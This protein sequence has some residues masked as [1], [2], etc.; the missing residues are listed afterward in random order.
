MNA[1]LE[2]PTFDWVERWLDVWVRDMLDP[3]LKLGVPNR[4]AVA[5]NEGWSGY[6]DV[7]EQ[8]E[9]EGNSRAVDIINATLPGLSKIEFAAL[10]HIKLRA[11]FEFP[12]K[13][14]GPYADAKLKIGAKLKA[15]DF[16]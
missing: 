15:A 1:V 5:L 10:M 11:R 6:R 2:R 4:A 3:D 9:G 13:P 12:G 14:D 7:T 8:W 16:S